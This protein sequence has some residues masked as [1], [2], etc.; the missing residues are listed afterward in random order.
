MRRRLNPIRKERAGPGDIAEADGV[1][2]DD[3]QE[4]AIIREIFKRSIEQR[5]GVA[6]NGGE[7]GPQFMG[8]IGYEV[9][10]HLLLIMQI[11]K[12]VQNDNGAALRFKA[13]RNSP[14]F[15]PAAMGR[16]QLEVILLGRS[17]TEN[18][19]EDIAQGGLAHKFI[20]AAALRNESAGVEGFCERLV[21]ENNFEIGINGKNPSVMQARIASR[22]WDSRLTR[23]MTCCTWRDMLRRARER[24]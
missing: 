13:K 18:A 19:F 15:E 12:V 16:G 9:L 6:A 21:A 23:S 5:F 11:G 22:R 17:G 14:R 2:E 1:R 4:F 7:R 20:K 10:A 3:F 8:D 24:R